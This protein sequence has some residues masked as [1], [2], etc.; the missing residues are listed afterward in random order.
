MVI[1]KCF[2]VAVLELLSDI[3]GDTEKGL[4]GTDIHRFL[5]QAGIEDVSEKDQ[6]LAKRK[7]LFNAFANFQNTQKCSNNILKFIQLVLT[8]SRFIGKSNSYEELRS[9]VNQQL[10]FE[11]YKILEN[12]KFSLVQVAST[13]SDV[14]L[15]VENLK[16]ELT[17]RNAHIQIFK[18]CTPG[19][20]PL[21]RKVL[22]C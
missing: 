2:N 21:E 10:A 8:P 6:F 22:T 18:Y 11:G 14:E 19:I 1:R 20:S 5:L 17:E 7:R 4:T 15:K 12:G 3:L 13:I 16:L 9:K